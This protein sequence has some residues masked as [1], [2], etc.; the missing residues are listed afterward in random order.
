MDDWEENTDENNLVEYDEL[1][2][3]FE[4]LMMVEQSGRIPFEDVEDIIAYVDKK[5]AENV[6]RADLAKRI[7]SQVLRS[8]FIKPASIRKGLRQQLYT[9][10]YKMLATSLRYYHFHFVTHR[11]VKF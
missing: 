7:R 9:I 3:S 2:A 8:F 6:S 10:I 1:D 5:L 4:D 11:W